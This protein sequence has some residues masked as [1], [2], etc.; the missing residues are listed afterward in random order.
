MSFIEQRFRLNDAPGSLGLS[1][2]ADGLTL[3]GVPL[4]RATDQG[5]VPREAAE[6]GSLLDAAYRGE[7]DSAERLATLS[8]VAAALNNGDLQ[9]AMVA[10][11]LLQLPELDWEA[12][13]RLARAADRLAKYDPNEP[14]NA[15][16]EWTDDGGEGDE[17]RD[18]GE[19]DGDGENE[20]GE[21]E[22]GE[23]EDGEDEDVVPAVAHD[24]HLDPEV[25]RILKSRST[26]F[27]QRYDY[28][29]PVEFAEA[30]TQFGWQLG[31]KA[32]DFSP[33]A[34]QAAL[35]EYAFLQDRLNFWL[36]Y[37]FK[38]QSA[39]GNLQSAAL[40]LYQGAITGGLI[41]VG[42]KLGGLPQSMLDVAGAA[43]WNDG[44]QLTAGLKASK[45]DLAG[46]VP[47]RD[48]EQLGE[49]GGIVDNKIVTIRWNNGALEQGFPWE[50]F[51]DR[52]MRGI[53]KLSPGAKAFDRYN[54]AERRAISDKTLNT[55]SASYIKKPGQIYG[56]LKRYIDEV[57][58][59]KPRTRS[60]LAIAEIDKRSIYLAVPDFTSGAQWRHVMRA[61]LY[62]KKR[63]VSLV[64]T[65]IRLE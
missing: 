8:A 28:L 37:D 25:A 56:K 30:V 36:G 15:E 9:R 64:V 53:R 26:V 24:P 51:L 45:L 58:D 5:L 57:A 38:P 50:Y 20:D 44:V 6:I 27:A 10:A 59:Y 4:L 48:T 12:A 60:E 62:A 2:R 31:A 52:V 43:V 61:V 7:I 29:G 21:N 49:I 34:R 14:R 16:G 65:R 18:E 13:A 47:I 55:L 17:E 40:T 1:C 41:A 32:R 19:A 22:D 46:T 23:D 54:E 11:L 42:G 33:P 35:A 3:A 39:Q 63:N